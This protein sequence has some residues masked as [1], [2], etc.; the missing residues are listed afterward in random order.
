MRIC[1]HVSKCVH[2]GSHNA[3]NCPTKV[4]QVVAQDA[5][6]IWLHSF[7]AYTSF[8]DRRKIW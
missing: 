4:E 7:S 1:V 5:E 3:L 8:A 2:S 6:P